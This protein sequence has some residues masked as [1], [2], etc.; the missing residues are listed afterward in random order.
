M[1]GS[2]Q[3]ELW[4]DKWTAVSVDRSW[5]AQAEHTVLITDNGVEV[6]TEV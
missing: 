4:P 3:M 6:L 2:S 1:E 5:S